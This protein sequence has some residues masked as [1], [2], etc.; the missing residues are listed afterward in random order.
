VTN[1]SAIKMPLAKPAALTVPVAERIQQLISEFGL[2]LLLLLLVAALVLSLFMRRRKPGED[3]QEAAVEDLQLQI[4]EGIIEPEDL[5][6]SLQA[7]DVEQKSEIRDQLER[8]IRQKPEA[9][10]SLLRNWLTEEI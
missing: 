7:I 8:L 9:V 3:A 5:S 10:A 4:A 2:P 6:Q 1:V